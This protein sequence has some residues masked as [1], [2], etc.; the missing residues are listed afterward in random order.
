MEYF[1]EWFTYV[2]HVWVGSRFGLVHVLVY[3]LGGSRFG[4]CFGLVHFGLVHALVLIFPT[5]WSI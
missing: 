5:A 3:V 4:S 2:F 1:V